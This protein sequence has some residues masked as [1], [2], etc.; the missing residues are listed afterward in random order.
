MGSIQWNFQKWKYLPV[1]LLF[2]A[3]KTVATL[4]YFLKLFNEFITGCL[5]QVIG[6]Q[7]VWDVTYCNQP[8]TTFNAWLQTH[9]SW[10]LVPLPT[11]T[12]F[13]LILWSYKLSQNISYQWEERKRKINV[14]T[15]VS[16]LNLKTSLKF[17]FLSMIK[18]WKLILCIWNRRLC[19]VLNSQTAFWL[20]VAKQWPENSLISF[21]KIIFCKIS[22]SKWAKN[23]DWACNT[24]SEGWSL[25]LS[26]VLRNSRSLL[27]PVKWKRL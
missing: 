2:W 20:I 17:C 13:Y 6:T 14:K 19:E 21:K 22:R 9:S 15:A 4:V 26:I 10:N 18:C 11:Y 27:W 25:H 12:S 8:I 16:L 24:F 5:P 1:K 23:K 3:L 7:Q